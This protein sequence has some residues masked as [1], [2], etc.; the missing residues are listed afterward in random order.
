MGG[1]DDPVQ[2]VKLE[3][4]RAMASVLVD[5]VGLD[6]LEK[7]ER[8]TLGAGLIAKACEVSVACIL[9]LD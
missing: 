9:W 3:A 8:E 4:A 6:Q 1:L 7:K 2:E 5:G